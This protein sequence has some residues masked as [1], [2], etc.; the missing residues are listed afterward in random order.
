MELIT[1][2]ASD[3]AN[4]YVS[5]EEVTDY[6]FGP[7]A[8]AWDN[9][10]TAEM[11]TSLIRSVTEDIE[12][13]SYSGTRFSA[14]QALRFPFNTHYKTENGQEI[15][16]IHPRVKR[17]CFYEIESRLTSPGMLEALIYRERG[18][19]SISMPGG[20]RT[21]FT[22]KRPAATDRLCLK[23]RDMLACFFSSHN[24]RIDRG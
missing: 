15:P 23:A 18:V 10:E 4:A 11:R 12:S 14:T 7:A 1:K 17:A 8:T 16:F 3:T 20:V 24:L 5:L 2:P 9:L 22:T 21:T 13:L 19:T 6:L